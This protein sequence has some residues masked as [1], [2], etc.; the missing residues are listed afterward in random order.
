M[1]SN[2]TY[3]LMGLGCGSVAGLLLA[4]KSGAATRA[5]I[6]RVGKKRQRLIKK[7]VSSATAVIESYSIGAWRALKRALRSKRLLPAVFQ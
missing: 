7:Q 2:K 1:R 5:G 4:P 3:Y 6:A